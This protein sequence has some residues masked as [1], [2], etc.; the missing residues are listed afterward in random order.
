MNTAAMALTILLLA[1]GVVQAQ[2]TEKAVSPPIQNGSTVSIEYT[3][4][5]EAGK[6]IDSNAGRDPLVYTQGTRQIIPGLETA[7]DGMRAGE[8][9]KV[10]VPPGDAYGDVD[11]DAMAE[12]PKEMIPPAAHSV[13]TELIAQTQGGGRRVVRV[14]EVREQTIVI[15]LNHPLAGKTLH[16]DV[17]VLAVEPPKK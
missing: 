9:K 6:V 12:V 17:K 13:G 3:L 11:P 5:D 15:D 8:E 14:K 10:S 16:F 4:K 1:S 7:L 2:P